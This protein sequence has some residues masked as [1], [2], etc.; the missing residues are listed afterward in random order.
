MPR[1][2]RKSEEAAI[3]Q[4]DQTDLPV[5]FGSPP[6]TA[7]A[8]LDE[9]VRNNSDQREVTEDAQTITPRARSFKSVLS[10][11]SKGVTLGER[12][13][14]DWVIAFPEDPGREIKDKLI[15]AGFTYRDGRWKQ[16]T[17]AANRAQVESLAKELKH[18]A[19][20]EITI[21]DYPVK[22]VVLAFDAPPGDEVTAR[23]READFHFRPDRTWNADYTPQ[24]QKLA[25]DFIQS[26]PD[27]ARS[28]AG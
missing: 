21:N 9:A 15:D 25:R 2:S 18:Q 23:L 10:L 1:K 22:Q 4:A 26:L 14:H 16:F 20:D 13:G 11:R 28:V 6:S 5:A 7:P 27:M 17:H 24:N 19:G 8:T 12:N 3:P